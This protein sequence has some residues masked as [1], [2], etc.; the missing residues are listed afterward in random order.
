MSVTSPPL[1]AIL[2]TCNESRVGTL[3]TTRRNK[4]AAPSHRCSGDRHHKARS[5][6]E[7]G[8]GTAGFRP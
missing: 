6:G 2:S 3:P 4:R 5:R 7:G 8:R 1:E